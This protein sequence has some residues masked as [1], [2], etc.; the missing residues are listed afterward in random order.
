MALLAGALLAAAVL[1]GTAAI[2]AYHHHQIDEAER[3]VAAFGTCAA[4][5]GSTTRIFSSSA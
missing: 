4:N 5:A 3:A 1:A 2:F